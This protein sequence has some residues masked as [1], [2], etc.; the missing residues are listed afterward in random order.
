MSN[1]V[2]VRYFIES[3]GSTASTI[4]YSLD[5]GNTKKHT[6]TH[7][8]LELMYPNKNPMVHEVL[9]DFL[10]GQIKDSE[11]LFVMSMDLT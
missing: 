9:E 2:L 8:A 6:V 1:E 4:V 5:R 11:F 7:K 10:R 3:I